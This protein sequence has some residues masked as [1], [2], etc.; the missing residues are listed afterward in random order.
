MLVDAAVLLRLVVDQMDGAALV[1][2]EIAAPRLLSVIAALDAEVSDAW[3]FALATERTTRELAQEAH[4]SVF[5][6]VSMVCGSKTLT[7]EGSSV[8]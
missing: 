1:A 8:L 5:R 2:Y 3:L 7:R 4:F 6:I